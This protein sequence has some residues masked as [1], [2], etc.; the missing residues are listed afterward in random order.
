MTQKNDIL[1]GVK[2]SK[3]MKAD[4][5]RL[6]SKYDWKVSHTVRRCIAQ[7]VAEGGFKDAARAWTSDRKK[8]SARRDGRAE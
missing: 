3:E 8:T 5:E 7:V 2:V 6:A 4:L 1:V